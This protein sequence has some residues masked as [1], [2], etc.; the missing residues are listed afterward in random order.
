LHRKTA[1]RKF[2]NGSD[3]FGP[4]QSAEHAVCLN[5]ILPPTRHPK[6]SSS[7][8]LKKRS[9]LETSSSHRSS[10]S[11]N[12]DGPSSFFCVTFQ[13]RPRVKL[14]GS[15]AFGIQ[16]T[17]TLRAAGNASIFRVGIPAI[18]RP[19]ACAYVRKPKKQEL[20]TSLLLRGQ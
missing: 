9:L 18:A 16:S 12:L 8:A 14:H 17:P 10:P 3:D 19:I 2:R 11:G 7:A 6:F 4:S 13:C 1:R 15:L 20:A 5:Y